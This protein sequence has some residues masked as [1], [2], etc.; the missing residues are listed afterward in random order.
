MFDFNTLKNPNLFPFFS[1][2]LPALQLR[3]HPRRVGDGAGARGTPSRCLPGRPRRDRGEVGPAGGARR[4]GPGDEAGAGGVLAADDRLLAAAG[5]EEGPR[6]AE[7]GAGAR[8]PADRRGHTDAGPPH[9]PLHVARLLNT[10]LVPSRKLF[11]V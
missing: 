8:P 7:G 9:Y 5:G 11:R 1:P 2:S 3:H 4:G 6:G 10:T